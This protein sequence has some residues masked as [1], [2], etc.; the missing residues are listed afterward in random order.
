MKRGPKSEFKMEETK[1]EKIFYIITN[2]FD[3]ARFDRMWKQNAR[4]GAD[5]RWADTHGRAGKDT[6]PNARTGGYR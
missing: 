5:L 2:A 1:F 6:R 4:G 3:A